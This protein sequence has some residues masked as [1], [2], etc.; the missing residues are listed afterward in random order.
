MASVIPTF[1][2][3]WSLVQNQAYATSSVTATDNKAMTLLIVNQ[4]IAWGWTVSGSGSTNYGSGARD[5]TNR[6]RTI[7]DIVASAWIELHNGTMGLYLVVQGAAGNN[8]Q[9]GWV[10]SYLGFS[11]GTPTATVSGTATDSFNANYNNATNYPISNSALT[12]K[13]HGWASSDGTVNRIVVYVGSKPVFHLHVEKPVVA[14][15]GFPNSVITVMDQGSNA[16]SN[17]M[18]LIGVWF[19]GGYGGWYTYYLAA[20][21][22]L[23]G[24]LPAFGAGASVQSQTIACPVDGN[25][26]LS[27]VGCGVNGVAAFQGLFFWF[28]DLWSVASSLQEGATLPASGARQVVKCGDFVLPWS[29]VAMAVI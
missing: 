28:S 18:M 17:N 3:T 10:A 16:A 7:A 26:S 12:A 22:A 21:R 1:A 25:W 4:L 2:K 29:D 27:N 24:V 8:G 19:T 5:G 20:R 13:W 11:G 6:W 15:A 23:F 14:V 9:F